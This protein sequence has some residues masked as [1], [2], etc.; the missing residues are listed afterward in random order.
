[1][2]P[3]LSEHIAA[4]F[5]TLVA[6]RTFRPRRLGVSFH[7]E[8]G[9][10]DRTYGYFPRMD[11]GPQN[12][13]AFEQLPGGGYMATLCF[14]FIA[15]TSGALPLYV[16]IR[17]L[18]SGE[19]LSVGG[20]NIG[21][22]VQ[23]QTITINTVLMWDVPSLNDAGYREQAP[24]PA[25]PLKTL[26]ERVGEIVLHHTGTGPEWPRMYA[27]RFDTSSVAVAQM[28]RDIAAELEKKEEPR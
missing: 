15:T 28:F 8:P 13:E 22:F 21:P 10:V 5:R 20:I 17:D 2:T 23:G 3:A 1:M 11:I 9:D 24:E 18:D 4:T 27:I 26:A 16:A 7:K 6:R 14:K 12:V 19:V 25:A